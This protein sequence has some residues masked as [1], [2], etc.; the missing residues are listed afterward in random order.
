MLMGVDVWFA[1][2]SLEKEMTIQIMV[3]DPQYS[4]ERGWGGAVGVRMQR[5]RGQLPASRKEEWRLRWTSLA[6]TPSKIAAT[7]RARISANSKPKRRGGEPRTE[8]RTEETP[9]PPLPA[10][11]SLSLL[12]DRERPALT[13]PVSWLGGDR[14]RKE[15]LRWASSGLG[16][17]MFSVYFL[18]YP[19]HPLGNC[20][21]ISFRLQTV[22]SFYFS[23]IS[24]LVLFRFSSACGRCGR[25]HLWLSESAEN[26]GWKSGRLNGFDLEN[27]NAF[28]FS[29]LHFLSFF[30][31][32]KKYMSFYIYILFTDLNWLHD[33][34]FGHFMGYS[35]R[36][37]LTRLCFDVVYLSTGIRRRSGLRRMH[38]L[39]TRSLAICSF[40]MITS[41]VF[42]ILFWGT[43]SFYF[44]S[45]SFINSFPLLPLESLKSYKTIQIR[46]KKNLQI[47]SLANR[48]NYFL[49]I[50]CSWK[51]WKH[52]FFLVVHVFD[53]GCAAEETHRCNLRKREFEGCCPIATRGGSQW[54]ASC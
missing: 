5:K 31:F 43:L 4:N 6:K 32:F 48:T 8:K 25:L 19:V 3:S 16:A 36:V 7:R 41:S 38:R 2:Q 9:R 49:P 53:T 18:L 42:I 28:T 22:Y 50:Q 52:F 14:W 27:N 37:S 20:V 17:S 11:I 1:C 33:V 29:S 21:D 39:A 34:I 12:R 44:W 10:Y 51:S 30:F 54:M 45:K 26:R 15:K 47:D 23:F 40:W 24:L 13:P 46:G 35:V